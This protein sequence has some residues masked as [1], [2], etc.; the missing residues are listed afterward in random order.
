MVTWALRV[1]SESLAVNCSTYTPLVENAAEVAGALLFAK[2]TLP[3]PLTADHAIATGAP[4][5]SPSS[6][7]LPSSA[8]TFVSA[9]TWLDPALTSGGMFAPSGRTEIDT[10]SL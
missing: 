5:G 10:S 6:V 4:Y 2:V 9:I 1:N 7:T 8:A 3:G